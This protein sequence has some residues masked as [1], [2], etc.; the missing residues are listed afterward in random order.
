MKEDFEKNGFH[1]LRGVLTNQDVERLSTPIRAAF[2]K[3][4]YDTFHKG[5]AYPAPGIHSMGPRVLDK[6]PEIAEVSLAHPAIL[7][8]VEELFGEPAILAQYWSIMRPP[9]AGIG[10]RPFVNGSGAHYDYKPWRCVGSNI[11]WMFAVIPFVDY[12]EAVGPLTVAPGSH[13]KSIVLPSDGRVH[14]VDAAKVPVPSQIELVDP[15]LKKGDVVLMDGFL[16]HEPRPNYG[17]SDRCGLYMKFHAKSS[18]PACGP[19]IYPSSVHDFLSA[20]NKHVIPYHRGDGR[21]AAIQQKPVNCIEEA[22]ILIEDR[23]AKILLIRNNAGK[24]QLPKCDAKEDDGASILDACNV[25]GSVMNHF[26]DR[27]GLK[28]PWL[29][30]LTDIVSKTSNNDEEKESRCRV[31]GHRMLSS[32]ILLDH[33]EEDYTWMSSL[34]LHKSDKAGEILKGAE[35][36][37]WMD[38]WQN[39]IDEDGNPVTRSY[40]LPT[41]HVQYFRYNGNG[42]EEG[43]CRIGEFN[44]DGLPIV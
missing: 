1:V 23:N 8:A 39:Q 5:P 20:G 2:C 4:D 27:F 16:W 13:R 12:T 33:A 29:S 40:G 3:G 19:T 28:L 25:M 15:V 36:A 42:N 11:N 35:I 10:D 17:N 21:F 9:G 7:A 41:T 26:K 31:Y 32:A 38:M 30:W 34:D 18:P 24:W 14:Q 37:K 43:T 22:Q 6:H 44:K